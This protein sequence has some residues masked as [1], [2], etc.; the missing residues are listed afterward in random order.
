MEKKDN[1]LIG[2]HKASASITMP[3]AWSVNR[4]DDPWPLFKEIFPKGQADTMNFVL[5]STSGVHG[6]YAAIEEVEKTLNGEA[7]T[8]DQTND[9]TFIIMQPRI[10]CFYYGNIT[11]K[12]QHDINYLKKL[13][14][15]SKIAI[16]GIGEYE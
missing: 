10:L 2:E 1:E 14:K 7:D 9:V 11:P 13:R 15:S 16:S 3:R 12:T 6:T 8:D 4:V 5:F